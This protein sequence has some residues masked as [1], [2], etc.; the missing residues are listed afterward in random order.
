MSER[1]A[2][3]ALQAGDAWAT[4]GSSQ[5]LIPLAQRHTNIS[6]V[7]PESGTFLSGNIWVVPRFAQQK[8]SNG[9]IKV[10]LPAR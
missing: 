4:V 10:S 1:E 7:A 8:L 5:D 2:G 9:Q 6:L 3:L